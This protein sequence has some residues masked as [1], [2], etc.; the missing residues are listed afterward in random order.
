M[1][2]VNINLVNVKENDLPLL[3]QWLESEHIYRWFGEPEFWLSEYEYEPDSFFMIDCEGEKIGFCRYTTQIPTEY[4]TL[5]PRVLCQNTRKSGMQAFKIKDCS[6]S[7]EVND[8]AYYTYLASLPVYF[9]DYGIGNQDYIGRGLGKKMLELLC[10]RIASKHS[11]V[12]AA[13]SSLKNISSCH[14]LQ[15]NG[16]W[17][18]E[19]SSL[20]LRIVD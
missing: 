4:Q 2:L 19:S 5:F 12:L 7:D 10:D 8:A 3:G 16:F 1:N 15:R 14:I 11:C 9:V 6:H 18:D 17:Y 20:F 13:T